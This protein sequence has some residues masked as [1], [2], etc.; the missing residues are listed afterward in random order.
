[1]ALSLGLSRRIIRDFLNT[2]SKD[3]PDQIIEE[4]RYIALTKWFGEV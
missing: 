3:Q 1:M 2:Q 4:R